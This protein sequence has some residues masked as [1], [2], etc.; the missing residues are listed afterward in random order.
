MTVLNIYIYETC[1]ITIIGYRTTSYNY[2]DINQKTWTR[3]VPG[4]QGPVMM[5]APNGP[6]GPVAGPCGS[7]GSFGAM[8]GPA[9]GQ[10]QPVPWW[11][12][13]RNMG[14]FDGICW[15]FRDF[16][17]HVITCPKF[18]GILIKHHGIWYWFDGISWKLMDIYRGFWWV[19]ELNFMGDGIWAGQMI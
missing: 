4:A 1:D 14:I 13:E 2:D 16:D 12:I 15:T 18:W 9:N 3:I 7:C 8:M 19:N 11:D 5:G 6:N 10:M 17:E